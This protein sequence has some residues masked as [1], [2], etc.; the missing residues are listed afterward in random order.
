VPHLPTPVHVKIR[1]SGGLAGLDGEGGRSAHQPGSCPPWGSL[2]RDVDSCTAT[3]RLQATSPESWV[4]GER[5]RPE[6]HQIA[7]KK[8]NRVALWRHQP[9]PHRKNRDPSVGRGG[10][11]KKSAETLHR[12]DPFSPSSHVRD[13]RGCWPAIGVR[14]HA[15]LE[16]RRRDCPG[17]LV[18]SPNQNVSMP[19][20][21]KTRPTSQGSPGVS[22]GNRAA[23]RGSFSEKQTEPHKEGKALRGRTGY[24]AINYCNFISP[25]S[26]TGIS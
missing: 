21:Y 8:S 22:R 2:R 5:T 23:R 13:K 24:G 11:K 16:G 7:A 18:G 14:A 6:P 19:S 17:G 20:L 9:G 26:H 3:G 10:K 1:T 4:S 15:I 25:A 12:G